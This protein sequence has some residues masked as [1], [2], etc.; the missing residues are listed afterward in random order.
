[1]LITK[2]LGDQLK[3]DE[4]GEACNM[5]VINEKCVQNVFV[6]PEAKSDSHAPSVLN[7]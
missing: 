5:H 7:N 6:L 2:Y 1:V 3:E 4:M